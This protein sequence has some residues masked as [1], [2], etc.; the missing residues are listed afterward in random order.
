MKS[1]SIKHAPYTQLTTLEGH[2]SARPSAS[3][4]AH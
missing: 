2:V 4:T 3:A 1:T